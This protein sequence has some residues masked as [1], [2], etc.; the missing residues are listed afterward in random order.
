MEKLPVELFP[1]IFGFILPTSVT[2]Y[3]KTLYELPFLKQQALA[4]ALY[5]CRLV[6]R[7]WEA[8]LSPSI[9]FRDCYTPAADRRLLEMLESRG[10]HVRRLVIRYLDAPNTEFVPSSRFVLDTLA[11]CPG[12]T[13]FCWYGDTP[14]R[15]L[16]NPSNHPPH[17]S[18]TRL[19]WNFADNSIVQFRRLVEH[20]PALE[21]L[22]VMGA[23]FKKHRPFILPDS[24][25]TLQL[26]FRG[27]PLDLWIKHWSKS[28]SSLLVNLITSNYGFG[29]KSF[30]QEVAMID[31]R[32]DPR[33]MST[34]RAIE[35]FF[36]GLPSGNAR[37]ALTYSGVFYTLPDIVDPDQPLQHRQ[38]TWVDEIALKT[39][40]H[41]SMTEGERWTA[42]MPHL[43]FI[44]H[45]F[46]NL[47]SI[48]LY[49]DFHNWKEKPELQAFE[50]FVEARGITLRYL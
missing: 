7:R 44:S 23:I 50:A 24:V 38:Y 5:A 4:R 36:R 33:S 48:D 35:G 29:F 26:C 42:L 37:G 1:V 28:Q 15:F 30:S 2:T 43:E 17:Q 21:H 25:T 32:P 34:K 45:C 20:L 18:I 3:D 11:A 8:L 41:S 40:G 49:D 27:F 47:R 14:Y 9:A 13:H 16:T 6:C 22:T 46:P 31:I 12:L 39:A 10:G 19:D